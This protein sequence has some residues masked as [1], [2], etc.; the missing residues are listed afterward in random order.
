[1]NF[2]RWIGKQGGRLGTRLTKVVTLTS[3]TPKLTA[4]SN[5]K[6]KKKQEINAEL[7]PEKNGAMATKVR[8]ASEKD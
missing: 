4:N 3:L 6:A 7:C 5:Q 1:M 2:L 8:R